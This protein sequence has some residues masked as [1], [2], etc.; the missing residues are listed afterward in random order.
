MEVTSM[1]CF[2]QYLLQLCQTYKA[3]SDF[4]KNIILK[5]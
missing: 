4:A 2:N 1:M 5:T 3:D